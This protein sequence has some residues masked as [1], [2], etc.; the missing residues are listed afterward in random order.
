MQ[1]SDTGGF[2]LD[3]PLIL[4]MMRLHDHPQ[5]TRTARLADWIAERLDEGL[6]VFDHADI[7]GAGECEQLFGAALRASPALAG[8]VRVITKAGIVPA[9]QD[10][11]TWRVKHYRAE[12]GYL[13]NA[14]DKALDSLAVEQIDTF[15]IHRPDPLMQAEDV[16]RILEASVSAGK[17][18]QIG[19]SNFLPEQWRWLARNTALPLACNQSQLSLAHTDP[20]FD[21]TLEAHLGD[22]IRW[23]AWSPLGGG[24]LTSHIPADLR[25][26]ASEETG[27]D[28]TALAIAW[29]HQIPGAPVPVLGSLNRH[30]IHSALQGV[31]SQLPRPLWYRLLESVRK[32]AVA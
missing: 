21:G 30:R 24:G 15:L 20:L 8:R 7:Y 17:V 26:Q 23:L 18:R 32:S 2:T 27:L 9:D 19:V 6:N 12:A 31:R 22:G 16:V 14:I 10:C 29:L 13:Q 5:L 28:D 11:S 4:G 3:T 1:T 25:N